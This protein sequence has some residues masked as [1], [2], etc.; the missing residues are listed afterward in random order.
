MTLDRRTFLRSLGVGA[1]A[2]G[3]A[4]LL[5]ACGGERTGG[6]TPTAAPSGDDPTLNV[7][8]ASFETLTGQDRRFSFGVSDLDNAPVTAR[9]LQVWVRALE[10]DEERG[11]F[12]TEFHDEGGS[13]LGVY[14]TRL[15]LPDAGAQEFVVVDG[16]RWGSALVNVVAPEDS[17]TVVPGDAAVAV[18]TPT[19]DDDFG[20][21]RLCTDDPACG[22][23]D[24]S[25]DAALDAGRPV[26]LLFATPAYCQT[27]VCGPAVATLERVRR[28]RD[29]GDSAFVHVEIYSDA[30]ETVTE[31]VEAW[32]LPTE[33]WVFAIDAQ[34]RVV[35]R[36]DGPMVE[37]E[38][39][40]LAR[41]ASA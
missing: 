20:W 10:G 38:L 16:D 13:A 32:R 15:D 40:R 28:S 27:A 3:G 26:V 2:A 36:L 31:P 35:D 23:H 6:A 1:L 24:V 30:G 34:G 25:L 21:Q 8:N 7:I 12:A 17:S 18:A 5:A 39:S 41:A 19:V 9:P 33:P 14:V 11:P 37:A 22:M 4:G 29:W